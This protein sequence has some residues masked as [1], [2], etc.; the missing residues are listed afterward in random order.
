MLI[1]LLANASAAE[2]R[3]LC[4]ILGESRELRTNRDVSWV[5]ERMDAH[6]SI[7]YARQVA[8]GLAGAAQHELSQLYG[9]LPDSRDKRFLEALPAWVIERN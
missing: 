8:H 6:G 9:H 7:D 1:H 2:R 3:R 5:L 4:S